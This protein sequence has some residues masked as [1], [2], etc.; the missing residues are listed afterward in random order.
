MDILTAEGL[1]PEDRQDEFMRAYDH[2]MKSPPDA[3]L[4]SY[5]TQDI[6]DPAMWRVI[7]AWESREAARAHAD[8]RD[9]GTT[10]ST[11]PF[12]LVGVTPDAV[13]G[14]MRAS[15]PS[16]QTQSQDSAHADSD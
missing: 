4:W 11:F 16:R 3:L 13:M 7:T 6:F 14:T 12:L 15:V 9:D 1:I 10:P 8:A 5:L 2:A